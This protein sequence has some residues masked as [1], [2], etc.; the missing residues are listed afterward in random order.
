M[1][2]AIIDKKDLKFSYIFEKEWLKEVINELSP[3]GKLD[4]YLT[5]RAQANRKG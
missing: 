3:L 2:H 1:I 5:H 4:N